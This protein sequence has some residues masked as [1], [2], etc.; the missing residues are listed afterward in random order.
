MGYVSRGHPYAA[1]IVCRPT[2]HSSR[3]LQD[4]L[5]QFHRP[6]RHES[7]GSFQLAQ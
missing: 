3:G 5:R 1:A 2:N 4:Y 7:P 6:A